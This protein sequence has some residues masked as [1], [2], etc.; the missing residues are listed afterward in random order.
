MKRFWLLLGFFFLV[1]CISY[2]QVTN[3]TVNSTTNNFTMVSGDTISW[4]YNVPNPGDTT[5]IQIWIDTDQNG[6][7]NTSTDVLWNYFEQIDGD[8]QGQ[9]GPPDM[10]GTA[11]GQ[12]SFHQNIGLAPAHYIMVF[13]NHNSYSYVAGSVTALA[14]PTFTIS[15]HVSAPG[16]GNAQYVAVNLEAQNGNNFWTA[17][18]DA[19]GNYTIQMNSD[20]SGNPWK[21]RIDNQ[22]LFGSD[23]VSPDRINLTLDAGVKTSYT[24]NDFTETTASATVSGT[25]KDGNGNPVVNLG[26]YLSGNNGAFNRNGKT[27]TSGV[28]QIGLLS[29]ELPFSNLTVGI[30]D[31]FDTNYVPIYHQ[32]SLVNSGNSLTQDFTL[33]KANSTISGRI[34]VDG[35]SPVGPITVFGYNA[36]SANA[37]TNTDANGYYMLHV[38]DKIYDYTIELGNIPAG[39]GFTNPVVHAGDT[40]VN[41]NLTQATDVKQIN[42]NLPKTYALSQNFPNPFNPTTQIQYDIP[43]SSFVHLVVYNLLGQQVAELVNSQQ[44]AGKYSVTFSGTSLSSGIYIYS[45][46]AG[47]FVQSKKLILLK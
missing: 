21:L 33:F 31:S 12:V 1:T 28:Y 9:N 25:V 23:I 4:S 35:S 39:Y 26:A 19:S 7:L 42:S 22:F 27:D 18:T 2:S 17:I 32:F 34:T 15:G 11:N 45:I 29:S 5:F 41:I 14:S 8:N 36:D 46:R 44:A 24:G 20:T 3:L 10:D 38:T 47:N 6:A 30:G 16:G 13:K 43:Q 40:N 37:Q